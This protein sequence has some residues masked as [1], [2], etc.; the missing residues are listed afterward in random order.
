VTG[1]TSRYLSEDL[2]QKTPK[3]FGPDRRYER[4]RWQVFCITW[5]TYA[6]F[7]LTRKGFAI[8]KIKM[9]EPGVLGLT[10]RQM[11]WIDG[12]QLTA[13]AA[14]YFF[15]GVCGDR[16]G[17]RKIISIGMTGSALA[18]IAMGA[19]ST[20]WML[21][22]FAAVQGFCQS[23]AWASLS[24][25]LG[26][27]FSQRERGMVMGLFCTNYAFGGF[28]GG[29]YAGFFGNL[30]GW[31]YAFFVPAITLLGVLALFLWLQRNRPE[32]VGLPPIEQY[33]GEPEV[34]HEKQNGVSD[35][36]DSSWKLFLEVARSPMVLLLSVAYFFMKLARFA[37]LFWA[38]KYLSERLGTNMAQSA[39]LGGLFELAGVVSVVIA[40]IVSDKFLGSRRNP[41]TI[42]CLILTAALL[43]SLDN[44]PHSSCAL[45]ACL[46]WAG[47]LLFP[48]DAMVSA[49]AA[50]DFG[51]RK[52][53]STATG[54]ING[55]GSIGGI[56]GGT[57][58][59]LLRA[60]WSW[61]A[62]FALLASSLLVAALILLPKWNSVPVVSKES[63]SGETKPETVGLSNA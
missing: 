53:A 34:V 50:I 54:L 3:L 10:S 31:R 16:H 60:H 7:F 52:G 1:K 26:N 17:T 63:A 32:D 58:P 12:A 46:F 30:F 37:V 14:G 22:L 29:V 33:H 38:P 44:L 62:I 40:G 28:A 57:L 51:T 19:S 5:L 9:A 4:W 42:V 25:N 39:G 11:S 59:G 61:N 6:S 13:Y 48:P 24:K 21:G 27:F 49:I 45:G 18:A 55:C 35:E 15:W 8:A 56:I 2:M 20:L 43:Y 36:P 47:F 23:S 41:I